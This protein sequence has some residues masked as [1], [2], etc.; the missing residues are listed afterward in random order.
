MTINGSIMITASRDFN[1]EVARSLFEQHLSPFS[2]HNDPEL[3]IR[4]L[5]YRTLV[6]V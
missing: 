5:N 3:C 2:G 1:R 6:S 4:G